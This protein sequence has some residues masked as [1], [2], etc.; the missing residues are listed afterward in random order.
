[1]LKSIWDRIKGIFSKVKTYIKKEPKRSLLF[2]GLILLVIIFI[3]CVI[4]IVRILVQR[5]NGKKIYEQMNE[6]YVT[7]HVGDETLEDDDVKEGSESVSTVIE[8]LPAVE[9]DD[10]NAWYNLAEVDLT[11]LQ[12][13]NPDIVG[14]LYFEDGD[15]ISYPL[16]YSGDDKYI[17]TDYL[18]EPAEE[19]AIYIEKYNKPDLSDAHTI[20]YGHNMA[21]G[22][23]F[24]KL[25][26]YKQDTEY[27]RDHKYFQII[28]ENKIYRY[29][30]FCYKDV[31]VESSGVFVIY[32]KPT[33]DFT[34]FIRQKL[35][36]QSYYLDD[37][38][39]EDVQSIITLSTCSYD[40]DVRFIVCG[41]KIDEHDL[42]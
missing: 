14:W 42:L 5:E 40:S 34:S 29:R 10:P 13:K 11:S 2:G 28:T 24:G 30:I 18:G 12:E 41:T 3:V 9:E 35:L 7:Q 21:N 20:I 33:D 19:G 36:P 1:M 4:N 38:D 26:K 22:T 16:L 17:D 37:T 25:H 8:P 39:P 23:M 15:S 27:I 31:N 6:E 32:N